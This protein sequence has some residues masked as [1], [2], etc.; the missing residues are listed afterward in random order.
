M[1][2]TG[3]VDTMGATFSAAFDEAHLIGWVGHFKNVGRGSHGYQRRAVSELG[4]VLIADGEDRMGKNLLVT[5]ACFQSMR[6]EDMPAEDFP[7][8]C[9]EHGGKPTRLDLCLNMHEA[10]TDVDMLYDLAT[11]GLMRSRAHL[12]KRIKSEKENGFYVGSKKSDKFAR[13]YDK[14]LEQEHFSGPKW[15]RVEL[16]MRKR[17]ATLMTVAYAGAADKRHFINRAIQDYCDFP[18]SDE[19]QQAIRDQDGDLP[20]LHRKPPKFM[21]WLED[22]VIPAMLNYQDQH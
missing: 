11:M 10:D 22:Q 18:T 12:D 2:T 20:L 16:Q 1:K 21:R 6:D 7:Q 13:I 14:R 15:I 5:G 3:H 17:Y 9:L 8:F 19:I 4:A